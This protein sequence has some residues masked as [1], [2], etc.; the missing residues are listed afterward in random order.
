MLVEMGAKTGFI[1]S[2]GLKLD[3]DFNAV[4]PDATA[5]Y[6]KT[7]EFD[8]SSKP[9]QIAA[10]ES[11]DN[12]MNIDLHLRTKINYA[13]IAICGN[14]RLE[15]LYKCHILKGKDKIRVRFISTGFPQSFT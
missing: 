2:K 9:P 8:V 12:V 5:S 7:F 11:P 10:P 15:D 4:F 1:H 14:G 6:V 13:F 3:Y